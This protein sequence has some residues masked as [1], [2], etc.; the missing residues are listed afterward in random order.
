MKPL[1]FIRNIVIFGLSA[2]ILVFYTGTISNDFTQYQLIFDEITTSEGPIDAILKYRYEPGFTM[3]Y[4]YLSKFF[5]AN[6]T[7]FV[8]A[9]FILTIKYLLFLKYLKYPV[10]AWFLYTILFMPVLDASQLRAAIAS[11]IIIY[12][13]FTSSSKAGYIFKVVAASMFHYIALIIVAFQSYKKPIFTLLI[14]LSLALLL[15]NILRLVSGN[16]FK[17]ATFLSSTNSENQNVTLFSSI[18][19]SQLFLSLYCII[20][21]K[22][23]NDVQKKGGLLIML[24]ILLYFALGHN[25]GIA[26]RIREV[27]LVGIFPLLFLIRV[28]INY[29]SLMAFTSV[30]YIGSYHLVN[31]IIELINIS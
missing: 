15:D 11:T 28:K 29:T 25:P 22:G 6:D 5:T 20:N 4:Y 13:L 3:L 10:T 27:S 7:F 1:I 19:V 12:L 16:I 24:G 23:F 8:I 21:W 9:F 14:T 17:V 30:F 31:I 2:L 18:S 26:H